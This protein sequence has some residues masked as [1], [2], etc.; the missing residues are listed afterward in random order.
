MRSGNESLDIGER[1]RVV[2]GRRSDRWEREREKKH[3]NGCNIGRT[4]A[5]SNRIWQ[6][7]RRERPF[8][9]RKDLHDI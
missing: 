3:T 5:S 6:H 7:W 4:L 2:H 1:E 9:L 8:R